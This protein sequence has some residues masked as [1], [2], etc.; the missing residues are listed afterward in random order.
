MLKEN[1][2]LINE[3]YKLVKVISTKEQD[4]GFMLTTFNPSSYKYCSYFLQKESYACL[5]ANKV[6]DLREISDIYLQI[7]EYTSL[8]ELLYA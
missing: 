2:Y 5:L 8:L 1:D 4:G 3:K 7:V 6:L